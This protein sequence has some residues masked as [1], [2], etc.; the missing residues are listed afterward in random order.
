MSQLKKKNESIVAHQPRAYPGFH[1]MKQ[2]GVFLIPGW[3]AS[4]S[5][6]YPK[7]L[8]TWVERGTTRVPRPGLEPRP[9]NPETSALT[10]RPLRLRK[11][12]K[13][14]KVRKEDQITRYA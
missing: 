7:H 12:R 4:P 1:S 13:K 2:L 3:D 5:Q 11:R 9:L 6:G 10:M 8:Y 14:S